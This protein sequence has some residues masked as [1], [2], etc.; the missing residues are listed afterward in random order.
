MST[1]PTIIAVVKDVNPDTIALTGNEFKLIRYRSTARATMVPTAYGGAYIV[2]EESMIKNNGKTVYGTTYDFENVEDGE[3][4]FSVVDSNGSYRQE[5]KAVTMVFYIEL[6]CD[7]D[8][9]R[10][11]A[12][13]NMRLSCTGDYFNASFGATSNTLTVQY[14]YAGNGGSSSS[15]RSM[16][17]S[18]SGSRYSAYADLSGLDYQTS[19]TFEIRAQDK[20][21]TVTVSETNVR[22]K[23][24]FH[25][26]ANDFAFEVPVAFN[27]GFTV[28]GADEVPVPEF[29]RW[30]PELYYA[31]ESYISR[32]GW[33]IRIGNIVT[34][35][36]YLKAI[37][38][39]NTDQSI[40][41]K[42]LPY[43]PLYS[44]AGGGMCSGAL[45]STNKNFQCFV[46]ETAGII[47]TRGQNCDSTS[48]DPLG[49]SSIACYYPDGELTLSGTICYVIPEID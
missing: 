14:R 18:K 13:G 43:T 34:I 46:A 7:M 23:P 9:C 35:G 26:G 10:P 3:F 44:A 12:D 11:D 17:V 37:C 24:V 30:T 31:P 36:F 25:W 1:A 6:T 49:T 39:E 38:Y 47:S 16:T 45:I 41:I 32:N 48:G 42:G 20:L 40:G 2:E 15:W 33:Y 27:A 22:S 5:I 4:R 8:M 19:Y 21:S 29:G 28:D